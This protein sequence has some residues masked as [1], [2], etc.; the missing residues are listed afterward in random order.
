LKLLGSCLA[1][2]PRLEGHKKGGVVTGANK[3]DQTE[4]DETGDVLDARSINQ[5]FFHIRRDGRRAF[6]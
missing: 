1:L 2:T 4:T 5:E 6:E 3:A